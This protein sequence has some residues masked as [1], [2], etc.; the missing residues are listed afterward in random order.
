MWELHL[1]AVLEFELVLE[2]MIR[3]VVERERI[4]QL[5]ARSVELEWVVMVVVPPLELVEFEAV[6]P[7]RRLP[8][9]LAV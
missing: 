4:I 1:A 5:A 6:A 3:Q 8:H 2:R 7:A 9:P